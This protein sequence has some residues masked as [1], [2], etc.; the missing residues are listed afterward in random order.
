M[1]SY[2]WSHKLSHNVQHRPCGAHKP[3]LWFWLTY[4]RIKNQIKLYTKCF[5][6]WRLCGTCPSVFIFLQYY[7]I[8][9][10]WHNQIKYR[11]D[12]YFR[13]RGSILIILICRGGEINHWFSQFLRNRIRR[14]RFYEIVKFSENI[15]YDHRHW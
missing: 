14:L 7:Y 4:L 12:Y 8:T 13:H 10:T 2:S 11:T 3:I 6:E 15:K 1:T 9:T 5:R